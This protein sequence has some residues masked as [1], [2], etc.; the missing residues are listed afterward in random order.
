MGAASQDMHAVTLEQVI[1]ASGPLLTRFL[2]GFG[3]ANATAQAPGLPN[4]AVWTLGH[5]ALTM[6]KLGRAIDGGALPATDF[7]EG[8]GDPELFDTALVCFASVPLIDALRYPSM[9]RAQVVF[10]AAIDRLARATAS[11]DDLLA[12]INW[13][14]VGIPAGQLVMRV[15]F[16][17]GCHAGQLTDLRRALGFAPVI[18]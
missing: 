13:H 10:E 14:G 1:R 8:H 9:A 16:H 3:D 2:E 7:A 4:H 17:N 15:A 12:P 18:N 5:C 6:H 11:A